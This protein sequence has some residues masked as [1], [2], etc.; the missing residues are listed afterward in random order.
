MV[1]VSL[2]DISDAVLRSYQIPVTSLF[3]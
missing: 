2:F 3:L 1:I